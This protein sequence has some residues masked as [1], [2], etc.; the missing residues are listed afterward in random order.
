M[1]GI[2][3]IN[4]DADMTSFGVVAGV[5]R[6]T[7]ERKAGHTGTLD[8][9]AT[10]VL[11]VMLGGAT[12]FLD[13][14]PD[15][16]KRYLASFELGRTTD[17]LDITGTVTGEY[18][19]TAGDSEVRDVLT[20]FV[21]EIDQVPP[22]YSAKSVDG[23]RLYDL[24]RKGIEI[25]RKPCRVEIKKVDMVSA[26]GNTYTI[27]VICSKGT[28][29]RS[30]ISDIGDRLGCGAVMTSLCRTG[31]MG[32]G[33]ENCVTLDVLQE[34]ADGGKGFDGVLIPVDAM[35]GCY[36]GLT[37]SPAQATRFYNGGS[38]DCDRLKQ[39]VTDGERYRVYAPDGV[40]LGLG[41]GDCGRLKPLRVLV[42]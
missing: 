22:M 10:G 4:K 36:D 38:L 34:L 30:L 32:F 11:P 3:C 1:T 19:V 31:A 18:A 29:I 13:Y 5:R 12:K 9:M 28:Y 8:P 15:S 2:I 16:D 17:T 41:R 24:A 37:V 39:C 33:I 21:G 20:Q 35:F 14:L 25:E 6:I 40:F 7:R 26:H 42:K 27:D 23:V